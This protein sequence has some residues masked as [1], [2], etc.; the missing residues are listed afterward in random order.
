[1]ARSLL[2]ATLAV[3]GALAMTGGPSRAVVIPTTAAFGTIRPSLMLVAFSDLSAQSEAEPAINHIVA[4]G[5][6]RGV[7]S[8]EFAPDAPLTRGDFLVAIQHMFKLPR[9]SGGTE[10]TDIAPSDPMYGAVKAVEPYLGRQMLCSGCALGTNLLPGDSVSRAEA[11]LVLAQVLAAQKKLTLPSPAETD[12]ILAGVPDSAWLS[13]AA[14]PYFA[15]AVQNGIMPAG[16]QRR[17]A[18]DMTVSRASAA[19]LLDSVQRR[20]AIPEVQPP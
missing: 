5:I 10:F 7:T 2:T 8:T 3:A 20:L 16:P 19:V 9:R 15:G 11:T 17:I 13:P 6:L 14:R 4:Q 18:P 12:A 1:M